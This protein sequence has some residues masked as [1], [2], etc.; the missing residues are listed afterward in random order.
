MTLWRPYLIAHVLIKADRWPVLLHPLHASAHT[1]LVENLQYCDQSQRRLLFTTTTPIIQEVGSIS[2]CEMC[3]FGSWGE[4]VFLVWEMTR[5]FA[6]MS[7]R[8]LPTRALFMLPKADEQPFLTQI[9]HL[10]QRSW[11]SHPINR[12]DGQNQ[13]S[14]RCA[15]F[16]QQ[17]RKSWKATSPDPPKL[18]SHC[19]VLDGHAE[20]R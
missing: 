10:Y 14:E 8:T 1:N 20:A 9:P 6:T 13:C 12:Q 3:S 11:E 2:Q 7:W 18:E 5:F 4:Q 17:R 15:Q 19:Q 16:H